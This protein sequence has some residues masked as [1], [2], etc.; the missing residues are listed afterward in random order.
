MCE[1]ETQVDLFWISCS[2]LSQMICIMDI[3]LYKSYYINEDN[4][5]NVL[6]FLLYHTWEKL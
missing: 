3:E 2:H 1:T 6:S 5:A 4:V